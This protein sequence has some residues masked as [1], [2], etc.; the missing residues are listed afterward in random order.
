MHALVW[1]D[2]I[3]GYRRRYKISEK[4]THC[5][6][7]RINNNFPVILQNLKEKLIKKIHIL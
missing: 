7:T 3:V 5:P 4:V 6:H 1:A 2:D